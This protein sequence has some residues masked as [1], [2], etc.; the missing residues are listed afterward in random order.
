MFGD[1]M[2]LGNE[3]VGL[4]SDLLCHRWSHIGADI[5][6]NVDGGKWLQPSCSTHTMQTKEMQ[7]KLHPY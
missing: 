2:L 6:G 5:R 3:V 7:Y 4:R 1:E